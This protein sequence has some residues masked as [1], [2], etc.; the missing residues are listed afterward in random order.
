MAFRAY[1]MAPDVRQRA[2]GI[3][4]KKKHM[5]YTESIWSDTAV[6]LLVQRE[7]SLRRKGPCRDAEEE[8]RSDQR[9]AGEP[10]EGHFAISDS[11]VDDEPDEADETDETDGASD[12]DESDEDD[13]RDADRR[14]DVGMKTHFDASRWSSSDEES[15]PEDEASA[16]EEPPDRVLEL[17]L[18]LCLSL[19]TQPLM[20]GKPNS[21]V[22]V[23]FSGILG[24]KPQS[25][26]FVPARSYTTHLSVLIYN[27]RL[28]FLENALPLRSYPL[29]G[30]S[31]RPRTNQLERLEPIRKRYMVM[32]S[33][34]PFEELVSLRNFG[35][36]MARSDTPPFLLRWS[37]DGQSVSLDGE[38]DVTMAKFRRL[39]DHF[40]SEAETLCSELMFRWEPPVD[41][42]LVKD[43]MTN[44]ENGFS[45]V[46]HPRNNLQRAYLQLCER[47]CSSHLS[48]LYREGGWNWPAI[49][50]YFR[51]EDAFR[52]ALLGCLDATGG[53]KPRCS[54]LLSLYCVNGEFGPRGV[55]VYNRAMVYVVRHHK[56]KRNTNREF[57][58][59]RFLP[60][61][62]G[63][64]LYKYLVY[65]RPFVDMLHREG[66]EGL[67]TGGTGSP[68][69]FRL[70][71]ALGSKPWPTG[72]LT[73]VLKR[74]TSKVFGVSINSRQFRQLCIGITEKHISDASTDEVKNHWRAIRDAVNGP[75]G[76]CG[77]KESVRMT[78]AALCA[79]DGRILGKVLARVA[80]DRDGINLDCEHAARQWFERQNSLGSRWIPQILVVFGVLV[81]AFDFLKS[82]RGRRR[83]DSRERDL[84]SDLA[85]K[86]SIND[87]ATRW[88][89]KEEAT[90]WAKAVDWWKDK[91]A[92]CV[93]R[94]W[95]GQQVSHSLRSCESGGKQHLRKE[96]GEAIFQEGFR[97][98]GGCPDYAMPRDFCNAWM[99]R[100][101]GGWENCHGTKCQYGRLIYDTIIGL[102][103]SK[104]IKFR[105]QLIE[106]MMDD[107][108]EDLDDEGVAAWLGTAV[109]VEDIEGSE[110]L[111]QLKAWTDM[112]QESY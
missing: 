22:L 13:D 62:V 111:R 107:G 70:E 91:C 43:D 11:D 21:T 100:A 82:Q 90:D 35:R 109:T 68:L 102:F 34:S 50:R 5:S 103:Y 69:L 79:W 25:Q 29:L 17:L 4:L 59:A 74:A 110:I 8:E 77:N 101:G 73:T 98:L 41:L 15:S 89:T 27:L 36:V 37:D 28:L 63:H 83:R 1:R 65:I 85:S 76:L 32:G 40:I 66:R 7:E 49:F 60:A 71:A 3:R 92:H 2:T 19:G 56:A 105:N 39:C 78:I 46:S 80:S 54:E 20:D 12:T 9:G 26:T 31:R 45:F 84:D 30:I 52:A 51:R 33:Q 55:Y 81:S 57:I 14:D 10:E 16:D 87:T 6:V 18:G 61:Q 93:G 75:D 48:K 94:G 106:S 42:S 96:L 64:L 58:V 47:A 38:V 23:Y 104:T 99:R 97:A 86:D 53:Q 88:G 108:I 72:R 67:W 95:K 44:D 112:V 24:L